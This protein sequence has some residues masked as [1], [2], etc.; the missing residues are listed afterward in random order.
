L[1]PFREAA[2]RLMMRIGAA[3]GDER[4]VITAFQ[5]C[6]RALGQLDTAPAPATRQL[7]ETLR[8]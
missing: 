6:E 1:D 2:W 8:R 5:D 7:L 3:F 4:R